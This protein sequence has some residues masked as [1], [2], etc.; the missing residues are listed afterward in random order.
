MNNNSTVTIGGN[1]DKN[2]GGENRVN[3]HLSNTYNIYIDK[4]ENKKMKKGQQPMKL[5]III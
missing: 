3:S 5:K 4:K 2:N 1:I